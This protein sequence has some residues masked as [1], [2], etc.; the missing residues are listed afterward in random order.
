MGHVHVSMIPAK[1]A[2]MCS[3]CL[4]LP[5]SKVSLLQSAF[6]KAHSKPCKTHISSKC[7]SSLTEIGLNLYH[8]LLNAKCKKPKLCSLPEIHRAESVSLYA[9]EA[10]IHSGVLYFC[11]INSP[12]LVHFHGQP[13]LVLLFYILLQQVDGVHDVQIV[14][15]PCAET[16]TMI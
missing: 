7:C 8:V 6:C 4:R 10:K 2:H 16:S 5:C 12:G 15:I 9:E 13:H 1:H 14:A 3:S 11:K